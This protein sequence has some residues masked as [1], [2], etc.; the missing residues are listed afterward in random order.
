MKAPWSKRMLTALVRLY[1]LALRL[2]PASFLNEYA[3]EMQEVFRLRLEDAVSRGR[4]ALLRLVFKEALTL[5]SGAIEAH[6]QARKSPNFITFVL[7]MFNFLVERGSKMSIC[8]HF[9]KSA[10]QTPWFI[11]ILSLVPFILPGPLTPMLTYHPWWDPNELP[12]IAAAR[13]PLTVGLLILGFLIG[14]LRR[15]PRWSYLYS[16]YI[17][18]LLPFGVI[19]LIDR[20][21][22]NI[23]PDIEGYIFMLLVLLLVVLTIIARRYLL[24]LRPFFTNIRQDWTLLS[25]ALYAITFFLTSTNDMDESPVYNLQVLLPSLITWLGA[26]AYLRQPDPLKKVGALLGSILLGVLIWWWPVFGSNSGSLLG[27]LAVSGM[28]LIYWM[29]LGGLMLA[30]ILID[31]VFRQR[32]ET[33]R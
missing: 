8:Q 17:F 4:S 23:N 22:F 3:E 14:I 11:A 20:T 25:Y 29:I 10:E 30:P 27:L 32:S 24:F 1:S 7:D 9:P 31:V 2:Y 18:I 33:M 26:L 21:L 15:F 12:L 19:Y 6:S 13:V 16:L 28:L 5:P